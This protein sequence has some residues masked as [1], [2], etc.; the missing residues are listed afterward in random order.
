MTRKNAKATAILAIVF[1]MVD[2]DVWAKMI[3][4]PYLNGRENG[5]ALHPFLGKVKVV[6][7]E[8]RNSDNIVVY[9]GGINSFTMGGNVPDD[10][11]Y[12][13]RWMTDPDDY[14]G[15]AKYIYS[16]LFQK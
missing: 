7:S 12:K 14:F 5:Y 4:E 10:D 2:E 16:K 15:A 8:N 13:E 11:A 3:V 6:F 1:E 9:V